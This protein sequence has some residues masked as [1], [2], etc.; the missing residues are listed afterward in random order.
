MSAKTDLDFQVFASLAGSAGR[1]FRGCL[2]C[3]GL[4]VSSELLGVACFGVSTAAV[5]RAASSCGSS[6][7]GVAGFAFDAKAPN[8]PNFAAPPVK[9][10]AKGGLESS[11]RLFE[12][13][14]SL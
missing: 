10:P 13:D 9:P 6:P 2:G 14:K 11:L 12:V 8:A 7:D 4:A 5:L 1:W 3:Q